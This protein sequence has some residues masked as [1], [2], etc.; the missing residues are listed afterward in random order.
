MKINETQRLGA[1][2][3]YQKQQ[4]MNHASKKPSRKDELI[5]STEAKEM[6]DAQNQV[7]DAGRSERLA[8][9]KQAVATG[10]YHVEADKI[11]EKLLPLFKKDV[12]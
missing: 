6:L 5:I 8:A 4:A 2:Q 9:L 1:I 3:Y 12:E 11:A 10:T 7:Q